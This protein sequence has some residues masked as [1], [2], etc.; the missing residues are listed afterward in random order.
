VKSPEGEVYIVGFRSRRVCR[1]QDCIETT[2]EGEDGTH[3]AACM[4]ACVVLPIFCLME[5]PIDFFFSRSSIPQKNDMVKSMGPF[6]V[7]KV[8]KSQKK[9]NLLRSVKTK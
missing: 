1:V 6:D 2:L 9:G 5:S 7:Q 8:P 4:W 3:Q